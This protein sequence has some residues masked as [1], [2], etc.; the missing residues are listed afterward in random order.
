MLVLVSQALLIP[1]RGEGGSA[2]ASVGEGDTDTLMLGDMELVLLIWDMV[3][4]TMAWDTSLL[5]GIHID[6]H[7]P[8]SCQDGLGVIKTSCH[9]EGGE[10]YAV[11][12]GTCRL[13]VCVALCLSLRWRP[14]L[15]VAMVGW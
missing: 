3:I 9:M 7:E 15:G 4:H 8:H 12:N 10:R 13:G 5:M 2:L 14:L 11:W 6:T 1:Y